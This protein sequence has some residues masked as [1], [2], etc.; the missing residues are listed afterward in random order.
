MLRL[1]GYFW[2]TI[3]HPRTTFPRIL[4]EKSILVGLAPVV[5]FGSIAGITYPV[6]YLYGASTTL[7][8][9]HAGMFGTK[10]LIPIPKET[11]RLWGGCFHLAHVSDRLD[12]AC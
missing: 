8:E 5:V 1:V 11:Y 3:T 2:G 7:E 12:F 10:P 6:N 9:V 4:N